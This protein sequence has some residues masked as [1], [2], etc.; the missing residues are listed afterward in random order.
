MCSHNICHIDVRDVRV[1][2][3]GCGCLGVWVHVLGEMQA[4]PM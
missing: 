3:A 1:V 4:K 2:E